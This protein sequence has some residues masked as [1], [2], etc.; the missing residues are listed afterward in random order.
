MSP[1]GTGTALESRSDTSS[2]SD[3]GRWFS[4]RSRA[5]VFYLCLLRA[6][7]VDRRDRTVRDHPHQAGAARA[8]L[9]ALPPRGDYPASAPA[10][11][12]SSLLSPL[13]LLASLLSPISSLLH[14]PTAGR[15]NTRRKRHCGNAANGRERTRGARSE[16]RGERREER[17]EMRRER[18]EKR[19]DLAFGFGLSR[20]EQPVRLELHVPR[21]GEEGFTSPG[22]PS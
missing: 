9:G 4:Q 20:Q 1:S 5:M 3:L 7:V 6:A 13:P 12:S 22:T 8:D 19:K 17:R 15:E 18:V 21:V 11:A 10:L 2:R 14:Q 16:E